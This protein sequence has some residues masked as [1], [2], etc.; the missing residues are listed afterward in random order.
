MNRAHLMRV[1]LPFAATRLGL[2]V[3]G[4]LALFLLP[5]GLTLQTG[6]LVH[7]APG[8]ALLEMW[9]RWDSEWY[10]LI[11]DRGYGADDEFLPR[12]VAYEHGDD[13][14][15][16]PL[17]PLLVRLV[18]RTGI[19]SL[20]AGVLVSNVALLVALAALHRLVD[21]DRGG[22]AADRAVWLVA[23]FPTSFF[24]SAVYAESLMLA[25]LLLAIVAARDGRLLVAGLAAAACAL[26]KPT[27]CLA[28]LPVWVEIATGDRRRAGLPSAGAPRAPIAPRLAHLAL[29]TLPSLAALGAYAAFCHS[30]TGRWAP[31]L[32]RQA[33]WRGPTGFPWRA[34]ARYFENPQVHGAHH[35]SIDFVI[36]TA[37]VLSIPWLWRRLR[38]SDALYGSVAILLP[39]GST[40]WSFSRFAASIYPLAALYAGGSA[41]AGAERRCRA[42]L[43][44]W[45][46]AGGLLFALFAAW[47]WVG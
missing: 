14:G 19:S 34:F 43:G 45:L 20:A 10:L 38:P 37:A 13:T 3:V 8:P 26:S 12:K 36:A 44:V 24:L 40:L 31:F 29:V 7:H 39:L 17:Y 16:F 5:S 2:L 47:W 18:A 42:L 35:S 6:N 32:E 46:P 15:F 41:D 4:W 21:R 9:A 30:L 23:A 22:A 33:R 27:G 25:T 28:L 1:L 11:A